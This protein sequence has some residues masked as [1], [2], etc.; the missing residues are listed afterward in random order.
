M[1]LAAAV[2]VFS[3]VGAANLL[4]LQTAAP[5]AV[6][7]QQSNGQPAREQPSPAPDE[8]GAGNASPQPADEILQIENRLRREVLDDRA[9]TVYWWL[10]AA[11]IFLALIGVIAVFGGFLAYPRFRDLEREARGHLEE[12]K[13][14]KQRAERLGEMT[15]EAAAENPAKAKEAAEIVRQ[16]PA[17]SLTDRAIATALSLQEQGR[18]EGAIR[19]WRSVADVAEG[20]DKNM[21]ARAWFSVGY[22]C[23]AESQNPDLEE[24]V[25][26]YDKAIRLNP[27]F[28]DAYNN[29]GVAKNALGRHEQAIADFNEALRL[30]PDDAEAYSNRGVAKNALGQYKDAIADHD[31]AIRLKPDY[32]AAYSNRGNAKDDLGLHEEAIA[33]HDEAIRLK[34]DYAEGYNNRGSTKSALGQHKEAIAD[35]DEAIR[36][37]PDLAEAYY[38]RGIAKN[39]LGQ[40]EEAAADYDEAIR[41]KPDYAAAYYNR[42]I[43]KNN[44]D[45]HEEA[46]A[47]YDEAIRL[48][49]DYAEAYNNRGVVNAAFGRVGEAIQ[50]YE[51]TLDLAREQGS[52]ELAAKAK[53]ALE[54]LGGEKSS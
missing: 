36:L 13:R 22:L 7:T 39:K 8:T 14:I 38:N 28:V 25:Q 34:P 47:D 24:V 54:K 18:I 45:Q 17:A 23:Q 32:A 49:P 33:D 35:H 9:D 40:H 46:T 10:Q 31:E 16:D 4:A 12:I 43:T 48:K 26:A 21:E 30:T 50:D 42:G 1:A 52:E 44:L 53:R 41:L 3:A 2:L 19:K 37:K 27:G 51:K 5:P 15:A 29:R 6:E 11:A 20:T